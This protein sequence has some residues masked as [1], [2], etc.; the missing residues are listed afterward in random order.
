MEVPR[1]RSQGGRSGR[2]LVPLLVLAA[3]LAIGSVAARA[4]GPVPTARPL[5]DPFSAAD[6]RE[7]VDSY[8]VACHNDASRSGGFSFD[9]VDFGDPGVDVESLERVIGKLEA[10]MMPPAGLPRP[11]APV[12]DSVTS[13]L[14]GELD[15]AWAESPNPGRVTP[16]HRM[17]RLEYNNAV[18]DLLGVDVDVTELL[19]GDPT[20]D[21]SFDNMAAALPFSTAHMERYLSVARQ[22]TRLAVG[23]PPASPEATTHEIPL[24]VL[25]EWRQGEDLPFGTRGG[26]GVAH[27]FP[28]SGEYLLRIRLRTNWQDYIMGMGW[29]QRL[30]VRLDG[31][32]LESFTIGGEAPGDPSPMSFTGPGEPGSI[33]WEAYMLTGDEHLELRTVVEAGPHLVSVSHVREHFEPEDVPQPVERGRLIANDEVY[34][35][36]Q[37]VHS[38][39]IGGPYGTTGVAEDTPSRERIFTCHPGEGADA[40]GCATEILS[41]MAR[42]AYRRGATPGEVETLLSFYDRGVR[43]GGSFDAGIQFALEFLLSD[44]AFLLRVYDVAEGTGPGESFPLSGLEIASRLSFFLWSTI[45]DEALL[46]AAERGEL[47]EDEGLEAEVRRMLADPRATETLVGDFAAQWLNL[48]RI[49][50]VEVNPELYPTFDESL[51]EGLRQETELFVAGTLRSDASILE[52]LDAD[53]TYLNERLAHHYG[54]RGVYG[55]RFRRVT[56]PEPEERGGLLAHGALL[57]VTSYPGRTSPVLRG[58]WLL[59]NLLGTPPPPPPPNVPVLPES[60][61]GALPA[62]MRDRLAEHRDNPACASCHA[63]IDPL[64]FAL[65]N[66][67]VIG[68]WRTLDEGGHPVDPRGTYAGGVE[69]EGFPDLR[70]WML[71]RPER[72]AHTLTEKLMAYALG[73]GIEYYDQPSIRGIVRD[74]AAEDYRWSSIILGIVRSPAFRMSTG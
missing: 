62:S 38:L 67:D 11:A 6:V 9:G 68:G 5:Q 57:A 41:G 33:E 64:G 63:V 40:R 12:Y 14:G 39:E 52:L 26:I 58:K 4:H 51:L 65:E 61:G 2:A 60:G 59:D 50:E 22:V 42:R 1:R 24:H 74:A 54:I 30:D 36:Y 3:A 32:L 8:C 48:R 18:G 46:E 23:L 27:H 15:R 20:A 29:P 34:M 55:S 44:P 17:N 7:V 53:Y 47:V 70:A 43:E 66:F 71:E 35:G 25:Q 19:P 69:F 72:F 73:R 28:V 56:L 16:V 21:G 31:R 45:P 37:Q 10:R 49:E 13:W